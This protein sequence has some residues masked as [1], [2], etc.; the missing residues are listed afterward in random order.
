MAEAELKRHVKARSVTKR[1]AKKVME[2]TDKI[3]KENGDSEEANKLLTNKEILIEQLAEL[4]ELDKSVFKLI[5]ESKL[6]DEIFESKDFAASIRFCITKIESR[7]NKLVQ[8]SE[9]ATPKGSDTPTKEPSRRIAKLP[10]LK[11]KVFAG[12]P[13]EWTSFWEIFQA[14]IDS[15]ETLDNV[16]KFSYL[17]AHLEGVAA[18]TIAGLKVSNAT[19]SEAIKLLKARF[20]DDQ[21]IISTHM[22]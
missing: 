17:K 12:N 15:D 14:A 3:L 4:K 9:A 8:K 10:Q 5:D 1:Y 6:D 7:L 22:D 18:D 13:I 20:G 19:Y 2:N 16:V 21:I 11:L